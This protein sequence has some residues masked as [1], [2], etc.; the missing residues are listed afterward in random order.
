M[1]VLRTTLGDDDQGAE[2]IQFP[3]RRASP[4]R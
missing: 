4:K 2:V 3:R 1:E